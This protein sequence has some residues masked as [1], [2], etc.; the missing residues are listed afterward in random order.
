V[1][2]RAVLARRVRRARGTCVVAATRR[3]ILHAFQSILGGVAYP[4]LVASAR[5]G[6][7]LDE[8]GEEG[9]EAAEQRVSAT[10]GQACDG[11]GAGGARQN[12]LVAL[13]RAVHWPPKPRPRSRPPQFPTR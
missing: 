9:V 6:A 10:G 4:V 5:G 11:V 1:P 12:Q 3:C 2:A 8:H 13:R 7:L